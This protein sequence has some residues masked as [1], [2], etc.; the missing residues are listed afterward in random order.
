MESDEIW[1][2]VLGRTPRDFG[3]LYRYLMA[4]AFE[5]AE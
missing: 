2:A 5:G 3:G 1:R 4:L